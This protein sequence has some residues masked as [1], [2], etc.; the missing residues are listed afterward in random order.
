MTRILIL[1]LKI[2]FVLI[3]A[4]A[5]GFGA[6]LLADHQGWPR[7]TIAVFVAGV[8]FL[9]ALILFLRRYYYRRRE[10]KFVRR[11]VDQDQQAIE[12]APA[13]E[14]RRLLELQERWA[15]AV[16]A[17]RASRLS[18][19]GD[20]LYSLPWFM[21]FGET[22]SGKSTAVSHA[23]L[24]NILTDAGPAKGI[25]G[26]R[27]CDWWFFKN[28]VVLDSAGR[29]AVPLQDEDRGE[30]ERFLV[31]LAKYRRKEPL[32][33]LI[34]TLPADRLLADPAD[35]LTEYGRSI[36][37]RIDQLMRVL[38]AKFPV[39]VL[40]T[41]I[42]LVLGM[43]A[44]AEIL[45]EKLRGQ[46]MGLL[47]DSENR[48]PGEFLDASIGHVSRRL[49]DLRLRLPARVGKAGGRAALFP[50][51]LERL[52]PG[53]RAFV[54]GAFHDNPY[55]ETPFF[56][57]LFI[58]SGRQS[59]LT[60]SGVL[61]S[62]SSFKDRQWPL[63]ET[64]LGLFLHDFFDVILPKDRA[65]YRPLVEYLS[66]RRATSNLA[67]AAWLLLLVTGM[68]LSGL[69]Y[70]HVRN[71]MQPVYASFDRAPQLGTSLAQ[72]LVTL[73][74]LRDKIAAMEQRLHSRAW[75]DMGFDQGR[76]ALEGLKGNYTRWFRKYVLDPTDEAMR[77]RFIAMEDHP[78]NAAMISYLE[79]LVWR[80]DTLKAREKGKPRSDA[81]GQDGPLQ[82]LSMA[83]G[84]RLPYVSA[85]FPDMYRSYAI[86][87]NEVGMLR[88]ERTEMQALANRIV[89]LEGRDLHWLIDW[90]GT[91]P[92]LTDVTL[93]T[94][95]PGPGRVNHT[96]RISGAFTAEG[97]AEIARL[98]DQ[99]ALVAVDQDTF[100]RRMNDFWDGYAKEF[101]ERW[102]RFAM[103]FGRGTDKLLVKDDWLI[104]G[105]TMAT[106]DNP[107]FKLIARM[108]EEFA[109]VRAIRP[110]TDI[111]RL[112][113][114]FIYISQR[115][116]AEKTKTTLEGQISEK[117]K[118]LEAHLERLDN[119]L[120]AADGFTEYLKQL[121]AFV[122][123][124]S[125]MNAAYNF[126]M[127]NY[128]QS[129]ADGQASP[130]V[131]AIA[132]MK[133]MRSLLSQDPS[134]EEPF[135]HLM[136]GPL[137]FLV[138]LATYET[139]CGVND[140]W[141]SQVVAETAH[142]PE[143]EL[144][145]ALFGEP[146]VVGTFVSGS[147][148]PFLRRTHDGWSPASWMGVTFPF[149][150]EFLSFL[151]QGA[152]RRQQLQPKYTVS[153]STLPTNVNRQAKSEPYQSRLTLQCAARTQALDNYNAP[154]AM[155]FIWEPATCDDVTLTLFFRETSLTRTWTGQWAFREFLRLFRDGRKTFTPA[156]FP[157]QKEILEELGV[158]QIQV[159][160]VFKNAEPV[161]NIHQYPPLKV[162]GQAALCWTGLGA[163]R[164]VD[165]PHHKP[166]RRSHP[167][168]TAE[169]AS[170]QRT[171]P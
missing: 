120:A 13:H 38:G 119:S 89:E 60:R 56:R 121:E 151:D 9:I 124:T 20:P 149:R 84:G 163:G 135:W 63:P 68:G 33:G 159:N 37:L 114:E 94:F 31:L 74:L 160:Y 21:V 93:D 78:L 79:Y 47:N 2:L 59:G 14:R 105:A 166:S 100:K 112:T 162:P 123:M 161:L 145:S 44:L 157:Q 148:K 69:S 53:I 140:F 98:L 142:M 10:E 18:H 82:A 99:V 64:G 150:K 25:A 129:A 139:A 28:A 171:A 1:A 102:A 72:D 41:K 36:R 48:D 91:R 125:T 66:W 115:Y 152:I 127:Q 130:V 32:N 116:A 77:E 70:V 85:Y 137:H 16:G 3:M 35:A 103:D 167:P 17:L 131:L 22:G 146:G 71:A 87:E 106:L 11:V 67:L 133:R 73:G 96:V 12:A 26:T 169:P 101:F 24:K 80:V 156:D 86:W 170:S 65:G 46:A 95:W 88:R 4:A 6:L 55:Q 19:R 75:P 81:P 54:D 42:D 147:A 15:A 97:K 50:D 7:W 104:A 134:D 61:G 138:T 132:A 39:Y 49:K 83:F 92:H 8:F 40:I 153:I 122:P 117:I 164:P 126:A 144:W 90:A 111:Q 52:A 5:I 158:Q 51:E 165:E 113:R 110:S 30:W 29:Y 45:P 23:R 128:G 143:S 141:Q 154:N 168:E 118:R 57:G 34:V 62:L 76:R 108:D 43:T 155:D 58:S 136:A 107:Y 27:N 109:A